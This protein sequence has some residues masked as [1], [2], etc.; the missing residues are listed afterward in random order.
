MLETVRLSALFCSL[1][2][3]GRS[4]CSPILESKPA[5]P[6]NT[7]LVV[8]GKVSNLVIDQLVHGVIKINLV[9]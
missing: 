9:T 4:R 5:K 3:R 2:S 7:N 8:P 1:G 6:P